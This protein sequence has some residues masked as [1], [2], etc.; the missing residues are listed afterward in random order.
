MRSVIRF[1]VCLS[2]LSIEGAF[3]WKPKVPSPLRNALSRER[4]SCRCAPDQFE[5]TL[6]SVEREFDFARGQMR[7]MRSRA[8]IHYDYVH[9]RFATED[10]ESGLKIITDHDQVSTSN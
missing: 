6:L 10:L 2:I 9:R 8:R 4:R 7:E 5:T 1:I 3:P